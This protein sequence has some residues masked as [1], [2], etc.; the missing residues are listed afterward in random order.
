LGIAGKGGGPNHIK[1]P[2]MEKRL[3]TAFWE[4]KKSLRLLWAGDVEMLIRKKPRESRV[5][6]TLWSGTARGV[7]RWKGGGKRIRMRLN[8]KCKEIAKG[9]RGKK[10]C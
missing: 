3:I 5:T 4:K 1:E 2:V 10:K 6:R 7:K 9:R 8:K